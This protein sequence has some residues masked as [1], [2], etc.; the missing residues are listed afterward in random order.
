MGRYDRSAEL[1]EWL[2][3][4]SPGGSQTMS[5]QATRFPEGAFPAMLE[6]GSGCRVWDP[7]GNEYVDW[8]M[9][10]AAVTLGYAHPEVNAYITKQLRDGCL[11][12]LPHRLE[13]EAAEL[14]RQAVPMADQVRW[15]KTGS[16]ATEA[17]VR[18]ARAATGKD[19]IV[20]PSEGYHSWH[21][22]FS[23]SKPVH[24]GVPMA[25]EGLVATFRYNDIG[26]LQEALRANQGRVAAVIMEPT[27]IEAPAPGFLVEV[28]AA[29]R[30]FGA[31]LVFDE[32]VTGFRWALAGGQEFFGVRPD[33]ATFGKG[34]ANGMPLACLVGP[35]D[36]MKHAELVSGTFGGECLSLAAAKA[37]IRMYLEEPVIKRMWEAGG[38][39]MSGLAEAV[40][41]LGLPAKVE[42]Y[43]VHP[44]VKWEH[45]EARVLMSLFLQET[46]ARG[47]LLHPAGWNVSY[48]HD[49]EAV[50][51]S[52][53]ACRGA[54]D[55]VQEALG[56]GEPARFLRGKPCQDATIRSPWLP[57]Y[58]E[59]K[60]G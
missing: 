38:A 13:A 34:M 40:S 29:C 17:A 31:L 37:T 43:A 33:L 48:A 12:S 50:S 55:A 57:R 39:F 32:I 58:G 35:P 10:L 45:Q 2:R 59:E 8:V 26:S 27:L 24:P 54:L 42:G 49:A 23:A 22:W 47:V 14:L 3:A 60:P 21:S 41:K 16:E 51:Q 44:R 4:A 46:A 28:A 5:K 20:T 1:L 18:V 52:I 25:Y 19:V 11:F 9:G 15:V 53:E 6:R 30:A 7:D 56:S 36:L